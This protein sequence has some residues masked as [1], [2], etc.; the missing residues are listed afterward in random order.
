MQ[1]QTSNPRLWKKDESLPTGLGPALTLVA[2]LSAGALLRGGRPPGLSVVRG[3]PIA[4]LTRPILPQARYSPAVRARQRVHSCL[5]GARDNCWGS[6][7]KDLT[8]KFKLFLSPEISKCR[9]ARKLKRNGSQ[10]SWRARTSCNVARRGRTLRRALIVGIDD[11]PK[12]PLGGCVHDATSIG[13]LFAKHADGSP[14]FDCL[15]LTSPKHELTRL[16]LRHSIEALFQDPAEIALFYF[17]GHGT[18]NNLGGHLLTPDSDR[19]QDG[20]AMHDILVLANAARAIQEIVIC[21]DCC[22]SGAFGESPALSGDSAGL[23]EGL[24]V[25][26]AGRSTQPAMEVGGRGVFTRLLQGALSGGAADVLGRVTI[27]SVYAYVDQTLGAWG[28]RPMFKAHVSR[29]TS[30]RDCAPGVPIEVLRQL[31]QL[32]LTPDSDLKLDPSFERYKGDPAYSNH[33]SVVEPRNEQIFSDLQK[34]RN[35]R[36]VLP[37]GED[38]LYYAAMNSK[39]CRLTPLGKFYWHLAHEEKI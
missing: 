31:P 8:A 32:F 13:G 35:G 12:S 22:N 9:E 10:Y 23:R 27:A 33:T 15:T 11:Y 3:K 4:Q 37:V 29:L 34:L 39:S 18:A 21:L 36:L 17:S 30:L 24:S 16:S 6:K 20:V 5:R 14:N 7:E 2:A 26:T 19:N 28:Q 1:Q 25:L 38:H